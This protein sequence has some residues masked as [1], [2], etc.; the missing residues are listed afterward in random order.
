MIYTQCFGVRNFQRSDVDGSQFG[1][2][3]KPYD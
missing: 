3:Y 2:L 1:I